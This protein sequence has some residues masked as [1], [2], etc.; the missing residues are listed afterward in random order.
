[1]KKLVLTFVFIATGILCT[2]SDSSSKNLFPEKQLSAD[3]APEALEA[4]DCWEYAFDIMDAALDAGMAPA[5]AQSFSEYAYC[6]CAPNCT[7]P[8]NHQ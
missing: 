3:E 4:M 2:A 5:I 1:M 7:W 8:R 6:I